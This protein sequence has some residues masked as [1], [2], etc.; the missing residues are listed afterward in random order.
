MTKCPC[1]LITVMCSKVECIV[2]TA[3]TEEDVTWALRGRVAF[4]KCRYR[5]GG[6]GFGR[7]RLVLEFQIQGLRQQNVV[8][9]RPAEPNQSR[10]SENLVD[11]LL[12]EFLRY[13]IAY[14]IETN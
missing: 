10:K 7:V 6:L 13:G 1:F 3:V 8:G 4:E 5:L 11:V 9:G 2:Q 14:S 12:E